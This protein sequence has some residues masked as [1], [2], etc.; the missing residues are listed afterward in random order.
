MQIG[1]HTLTHWCRGQAVIALSSGEAEYYS[2]VTA[3]SELSGVRSLALDWNLEYK[4]QCNVDATAAIGMAGRRGLGKVK[5]INTVY[6][7]IQERI[8]LLNIKLNKVHTSEMLA[9]MLTKHLPAATSRR[10][11]DLLG[12]NSQQGET[13]SRLRL[14][15]FA[16]LG[17][18]S[19]LTKRVD[20]GGRS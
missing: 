16:P 9:D 3:I 13:A 11:S 14:D 19:A 17:Q 5:H 10:L 15:V 7:W 4:L 12:Q 6:M 2:L 18:S 20:C 1:N 8:S